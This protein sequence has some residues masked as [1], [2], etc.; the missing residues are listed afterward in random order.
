MD[1][2][3]HVN[4]REWVRHRVRVVAVSTGISAALLAALLPA[5]VQPAPVSTTRPAVSTPSPTPSP[6]PPPCQ[7]PSYLGFGCDWV[8]RKAAI[9]TLIASAPG[10]PAL[11]L[12]DRLTG[13]EYQAGP[14]DR[15]SWTGSTIK[16]ALALVAIETE[17]ERGQQLPSRTSEDIALMLSVSDD[18]AASRMWSRYGG[19]RLLTIFRERFGMAGL[20]MAG[21]NGD[22]GALTCVPADLTA[23]VLYLLDHTSPETRANLTHAMRT[24]GDIQRWGV[25]GAGPNMRPGVKDGWLHTAGT[26]TVATVG[27][28]GPDERY[29][30]SIMY[31]MPAGQDSLTL[32]AQTLTDLTAL[33]F[34]RA[35]PAPAII[36]PS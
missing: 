17:R 35:T 28:A 26:W 1:R 32:G 11:I 18:A 20:V 29:V 33:I 13:T 3:R 24:V 15:A 9:E 25:W 14:T 10:H 21:S 8:S 4:R 16:L 31:P 27:F 7:E 12:H 36:R 23:L 30:I 34:G 5:P 22:W 19:T 2:S 6:T